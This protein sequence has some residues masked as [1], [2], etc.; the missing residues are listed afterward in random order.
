[1]L[2]N[3]TDSG[4][5]IK[6]VSLSWIR[7]A[8]TIIIAVVQTPLL[9]SNLNKIQLNFWYIF[10]LFGAFLQMA[11]LGL[12]QTLSRLIAY[13]DNAD[14]S[15]GEEGMIAKLASFSIQQIYV[16]VFASFAVILIIVGVLVFGIYSFTYHQPTEA[17]VLKTA[18]S[19]YVL[20]IVF[21]L[22][23]NVPAAMLIGYRD[24][25]IESVVRS[26]SQIIYFAVL[27]ALLPV[28]KSII[29]VS[30][31]FMVQNLGQLIALH[32][33]FYKRHKYIFNAKLPFRDLVQPVV[34]KQVYSQSFPL[35]VN[36]IGAWLIA[37]GSVL[38]ASIVV[39]ASEISDY[40]INQQL[41]TYITA[42][43]LVINQAIGPFIA[44]RYIQNKLD[45]LKTLFSNTIIVCLSIVGM[46]IIVLIPC[47]VNIMGLWVGSS[48]YLGISFSI[49]FGL[50][51]FLEVQHSV[52][53]NFVWNTGAWPFNKWTLW[54]GILTVGLGFLLGKY[55][56]LFG[57]AVATLFS[58]LLTLNWYVVYYGLKRLGLAL[59]PYLYRV[60]I[61]L[62]LSVTSSLLL[63]IYI[64]HKFT[65]QSNDF[66]VIAV[67]SS[68]STLVFLILIGMLFRH[69]FRSM[70]QIVLAKRNKVD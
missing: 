2:N 5:L 57:I 35:V 44:K 14:E 4:K 67:V 31:A 29:L 52:V 62:S 54:A 13:I 12:V 65:A 33:T 11:D 41:F 58:R 51:T 38:M 47:G 9:F 18:F 40:A 49:V 7:F 43:A 3:V 50:I 36:Q 1:M 42:I 69:S 16:T 63:A 34:A 20:G 68:L 23:S 48:H 56:G 21:N 32:I 60:L 37:Q 10:F 8:L 59:I 30:C 28:F 6:G 25:G 19:I 46:M 24:V 55:Y 15:K 17:D 53:G 27:L 45:E 64:Q 22:L 26:I 66:V 61:P 70:Y 39:G